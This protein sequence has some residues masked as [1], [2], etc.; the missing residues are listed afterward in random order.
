[1]FNGL[2]DKTL[3][4]RLKF[5][6][7]V[8]AC[9]ADNASMYK[10][11]CH[12]NDIQELYEDTE[13][14]KGVKLSDITL[15]NLTDKRLDDHFELYKL[16]MVLG[17]GLVCYEDEHFP[18]K[19]K[20][21]KRPPLLLFY[22]GKYADFDKMLCAGMVGTRSM[23]DYGKKTAEYLA[24]GL[25]GCGVCVVSGL[26]KGIDGTCQRAAVN[27]GGFTVGVLGN[28]IDTIYPKENAALFNKLYSH[29]LV[30]SEY[31]PGCKTNKYS[32]PERNRIIAGLS[33]F[34]IVVEAPA[35]SG[36]LLTA[37]A[38]K[39]QGKPVYV[40]PMPLT[41][42]NAGTTALL[43]GGAKMISS[44]SGI[45][46]E[47]DSVL[48]HTIP[49]DAPLPSL[50]ADEGEEELPSY[51]TSA[52]RREYAYNFVLEELDSNGPETLL[53]LLSKTKQFTLKD[54]I[55]AVTALE[56]DGF[57]KKKAGGYYDSVPEDK[58]PRT[59]LKDN[60]K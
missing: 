33:D 9:G 10:L 17:M 56:M 11:Y 54:L 29:G 1:M 7:Y 4:R 21:I 23:T 22:K 41:V 43:R 55:K 5:L 50:K 27:C 52:A 58:V 60:N 46:E 48:P 45:L 14:D 24:E 25:A 51:T 31:W 20:K 6:W 13:Y 2:T 36:A 32:F 44:V 12:Y 3:D 26:A 38:A 57:V 8:R 19:L 47:Y 40:P 34:L 53:Q 15:R 28:S 37:T 18:K 39:A 49:P 35:N 59:L 16:C 30:I 42:E